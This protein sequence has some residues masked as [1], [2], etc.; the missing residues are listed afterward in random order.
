VTNPLS[1]GGDQRR[2]DGQPA[3][4]VDFVSAT[5]GVCQR[6]GETVPASAGERRN[7]PTVTIVVKTKGRKR[8]TLPAW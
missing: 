3:G 8:R 4:E 7:D 5:G 2:G 6:A 1:G